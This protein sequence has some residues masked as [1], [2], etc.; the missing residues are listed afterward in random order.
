MSWLRL[1]YVRRGFFPCPGKG[2]PQVLGRSAPLL[3]GLSLSLVLLLAPAPA[4][5]IQTHGDPEGLIAHQLGHIVFV[6]A[7]L[8]VCIQLRRRGLR[9]QPGFSR[10]YWA[11]ILFMVWNVLTFVGHIAEENLPATAID[12]QAGH[13]G[14]TLHITDLN[15]L[16]FYLAKLDHLVLVPAF[17][18][19]YLALRTFRRQQVGNL[20]L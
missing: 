11:A 12:R 16:V 13:L 3:I 18:L 7:M 1:G 17:L 2:A 19:L 15:G 6:A 5:A 4:W 20:P 14:R 8:F 10:L 9:A